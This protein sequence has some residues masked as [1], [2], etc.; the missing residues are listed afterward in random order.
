MSELARFVPAEQAFLAGVFFKLGIWMSHVDDDGEEDGASDEKE[1]EVLLKTLSK[2][3]AHYQRSMPL[4]SEMAMESVR[5]QTNHARWEAEEEKAVADA[6][7]AARMIKNAYS[8]AEYAKFKA[9]CMDVTTRV[10]CAFREDAAA[11]GADSGLSAF[12]SKAGGLFGRLSGSGLQAEKNI[13]PAEDSAL[14]EL[15]NALSKV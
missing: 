12:I 5:Q 9:A 6:A 3:A 15:A 8:D 2:L 4:V 11:G 1:R 7:E 13:S 14:T 10:A